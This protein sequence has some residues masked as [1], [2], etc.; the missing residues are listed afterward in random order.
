MNPWAI[1]DAP[2]MLFAGHAGAPPTTATGHRRI[3]L[4]DVP[5]DWQADLVPLLIPADSFSVPVEQSASA[6]VVRNQQSVAM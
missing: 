6:L 3:G 5:C 4:P 2:D 1:L